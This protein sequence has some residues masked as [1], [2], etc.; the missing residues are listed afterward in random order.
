MSN[1]KS[2]HQDQVKFNQELLSAL[3]SKIDTAG[4]RNDSNPAFGAESATAPKR[5]SKP[6]T[7]SSQAT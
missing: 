6:L 3:H 5:A 1:Q 2:P 7:Q 4:L